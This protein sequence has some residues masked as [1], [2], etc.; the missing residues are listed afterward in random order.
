M[1]DAPASALPDLLVNPPWE[2]DPKGRE[3]VVLKGLKA[4]KEPTVVVWA[5]GQREEWLNHPYG[6]YGWE[7]LP[8]DTD[9]ERV[10]DD[11][12][13]ERVRSEPEQ[14]LQTLAVG[15]FMQAP[16]ELGVRLLADER[17]WD[18]LTGYPMSRGVQ[19]A[20][21]RHEM[22]AYPMAL[23]EAKNE[24]AFHALDPFLDA[25]VAQIMIK[26]W[27]VYPNGGRATSWFE[28]HGPAAVRLTVPD[29]LRK[30]GPKRAKA[31]EALRLVAERHGRDAVIEA[32]RHYGA[33]AV[34]AIA[35]LKT[36]PLEM[37][38][39]PLPPVPSGFV[40]ERLP[41]I[42]LRGREFA[43]SAAVTRH[44]ITMVSISTPSEPYPGLAQVVEACDPDSLA[45]FAWALYRADE[46]DKWASP[47]VQWALINLADD[48]VADLLAPIVARWSKAQVWDQRGTS[49]LN[50]F[51]KLG[52][53]SALRHL[54][55]LAQKAQDPER[56][57]PQAKGA[58]NRIA[59]ERG[60]TPEQLADRL[61]PDFGLDAEGSMTLNYGHRRFVVGFDEQLKPYVTDEEGKR[62]KALPKPGVK[63]DQTLAPAAY[64]RFGDL[65]REVR[66]TATEQIRR[67][68]Q[69][70]VSDRGWTAGEFRSLFVGHPLL[71]HIVRR[72]VWSAEA[73][74][75]VTTFRIAEDRTFADVGDDEFALPESARV[76]L[77]HPLRLGGEKAGAWRQ[78]FA[79]YEILQ[80][81]PQLERA[82]HALTEEERETGNLTRFDGLTVHFGRIL[83]MTGRGW[84][85][86]K[87]ETGGFRRQISFM[88]P[89]ERH[90][91]VQIEPGIRVIAPEEYV[92]QE[93][94]RVWLF[95]GRF[96]GT[97][98]PFGDLDPVVASEI[99]AEF[100]RL[101]ESAAPAK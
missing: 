95:T 67:L 49:A 96:S 94:T 101:A 77:P 88:T 60:L 42:L 85:L 72:L 98:L 19:G 69:A 29:A 63:D 17:Y 47:G 65:K 38:P 28:K 34:A 6:K 16:L 91:M 43:L 25:D 48:G 13:T 73:D 71:W 40:P 78:V 56:I 55:R 21:A 97:R 35:A 93:I 57:R 36:D 52:T 26:H 59:K 18:V 44:V 24:R 15:L 23:Y 92:E 12:A 68:E 2:R 1:K 20:V 74:G 33:E 75:S 100:V 31:E 22:A 79:D 90:L 7:R 87:K 37:Y 61:L 5:P 76:V 64:K 89:D 50:V 99:L 84:E 70:M 51:S 14:R 45:V 66:N 53:D 3:P 30:P 41:R 83:G 54:H 32:A 58:L 9:W 27:G 81:F 11:F 80:P 39:N 86:G 10:A 4:P 46:S 8:D 62:R 82:V